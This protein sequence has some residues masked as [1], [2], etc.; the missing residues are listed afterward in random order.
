LV[1]ALTAV[2]MP[3]DGLP[4]AHAAVAEL[5]G[6]RTRVLLVVGNPAALDAGDVALRDRLVGRLSADVTVRD[7]A[8]PADLAGHGLIVIAES[9]ASSTLGAKYA[10]APVG[11]VNLEKSSWDEHRLTTVGADESTTGSVYVEDAADPLVAGPGGRV[12]GTIAY[13][14]AAQK[15]GWAWGSSLGEGADR[16]VVALSAANAGKNVAF[17]YEAGAAMATGTAPGRRVGLGYYSAAVPAL[18]A[19]G[20]VLFDNAIA[21]ASPN[22]PP[23]VP[24]PMAPAD[25]ATVAAGG[26][27]SALYRDPDADPGQVLFEI[28]N[29]AGTLVDSGWSAEVP[30]DATASYAPSASLPDGSYS[31]RTRARDDHGASSGDGPTRLFTL[32]ATAPVAPTITSTS[33]PDPTAW[34]PEP[35]LTATWTAEADADGYAVIVDRAAGTVPEPTVTQGEARHEATLADGAWWL[36]VRA[37]DAAGNWSPTAHYRVNIGTGAMV[38]PGPVIAPCGGSGCRCRDPRPSRPSRTSIGSPVSHGPT[39]PPGRSSPSTAP[40]RCGPCR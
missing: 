22:A 24:V 3:A 7:D 27:L 16:W 37:K 36:H 11:V 19:E 38:V 20:W 28:R 12:D 10:D 35:R 8:A 5:P 1:I 4:I 40:H 39:S 26:A 2:V 21:Y 30:S 29:G 23:E 33:H 9:V 15:T 17:T 14:T 18:T 13:V 6:A 34:I 32:D 25:G 31:W